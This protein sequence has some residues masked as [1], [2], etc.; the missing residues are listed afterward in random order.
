MAG[1]YRYVYD[2]ARVIHGAGASKI[3]VCKL[4]D[5]LGD[6]VGGLHCI[7]AGLVGDDQGEF[8][9][10]LGVGDGLDPVG[11]GVGE[12]DVD[13]KADVVGESANREFDLGRLRRDDE[14]CTIGRKDADLGLVA[15]VAFPM[16]D[17]R[18]F[19]QRDGQSLDHYVLKN[20]HQ[21]DLVAHLDANVVAEQS[22]D[23]F[24]S[25]GFH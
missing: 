12:N 2:P 22:V 19:D 9:D 3:P 11:A 17:D 16:V 15:A 13:E 7:E 18:K 4:V 10:E 1:E 21:R 6:L 24:E 8:V 23:E 20:A 25:C 14:I 5:G